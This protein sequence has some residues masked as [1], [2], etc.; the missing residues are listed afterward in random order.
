MEKSK[1]RAVC[2]I[3]LCCLVYTT[4]PS[5]ENT[6][7]EDFTTDP[8]PSEERPA[9]S[10]PAEKPG[11]QKPPTAN[12]FRVPGAD[13]I[14]VARAAGY[15][16]SPNNGKAPRDG[17]HTVATQYGNLVTSEVEGVKMIQYRPPGGWSVASIS[18]T[19]YMFVDARLRPAPLAP[20]W[21][22]RGIKLNGPAWQWHGRPASGAPS[23]SFAITISGYKMAAAP[24]TVELI[25]IVLQGP[26]GA[27]DWRAAFMAQPKARERLK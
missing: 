4:S 10:E 24:S 19:F 1:F 22:I 21:M 11:S 23:A 6:E 5:A 7:D 25:S 27:T 14:L 15:C 26:P 8:I 9:S 20:G 18:N 3:I 13:A 12:L 16:F 17:N 2:I